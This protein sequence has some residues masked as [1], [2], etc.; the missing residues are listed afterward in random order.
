VMHHTDHHFTNL[1]PSIVQDENFSEVS[2][3]AQ[4]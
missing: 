4:Y 1:M 2:A 3:L